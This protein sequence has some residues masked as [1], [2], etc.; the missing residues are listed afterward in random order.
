MI[1]RIATD[2]TRDVV[3]RYVVAL[4]LKEREV[5]EEARRDGHGVSDRA[6]PC[7]EK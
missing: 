2:T 6:Q 4:S 5:V 1:R 7:E 3:L